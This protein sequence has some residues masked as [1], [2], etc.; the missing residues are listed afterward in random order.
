MMPSAAFDDPEQCSPDLDKI[1]ATAEQFVTKYAVDC[2]EVVIVEIRVIG[3]VQ[4]A[5]PIWI[6]GSE[7]R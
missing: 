1:K 5:R 3:W 7:K 4:Y 2:N 6:D